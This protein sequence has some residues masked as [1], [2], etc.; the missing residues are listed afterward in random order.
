MLKKQNKKKEHLVWKILFIKNEGTAPA[1]F[2]DIKS[3]GDSTNQNSYLWSYFHSWEELF[4]EVY[5]VKF[6]LYSKLL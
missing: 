1:N 5:M 6:S 4:S 2:H 3:G